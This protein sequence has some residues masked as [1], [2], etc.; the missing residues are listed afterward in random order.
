MENVT[1]WTLEYIALIS[2]LT[3]VVFALVLG[4]LELKDFLFDKYI[5]KL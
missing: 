3:P 2:V 4:L 5:Y 1:K